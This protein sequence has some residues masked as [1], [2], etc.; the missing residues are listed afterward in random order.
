LLCIYGIFLF[1]VC[2]DKNLRGVFKRIFAPTEKLA[3]SSFKNCLLAQLKLTPR[4]E[5]D[6]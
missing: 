2:W 5:V 3:P 1:L 6:A 4:G